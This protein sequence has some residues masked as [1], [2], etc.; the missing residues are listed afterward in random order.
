VVG[1]EVFGRKPNYDPRRDPVVRMEAAKLRARLAQYYAGEGATA[2]WVIELPKGGYAPVL[3]PAAQGRSPARVALSRGVILAAAL[4][5]LIAGGIWWHAWKREPFTIAVLPLESLSPDP[6]NEPFADG[7][8]GEIIRNLSLIEGISVRS[9]ASSFAFKGK[10]LKLR[11]AAGQLDV[12][13]VLDG[14][15]SRD[16]QNLRVNAELVRIRDNFLLWSGCFDRELT[17][18]FAIQDEISSG[19]VNGL[20]LKLGPG[21]AAVRNE[22]GG[23]R[24]LPASRRVKRLDRVWDSFAAGGGALRTS[25]AAGSHVCAGLRGPRR[26]LCTHVLRSLPEP[27][28]D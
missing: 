14:S 20:R 16:G 27:D 7:L 9:R 10:P 5:I 22:S 23:V 4:S 8:T 2:S 3:R 11:E 21:A 28:G 6:A 12:D 1:V 24:P 26:C 19:I 25:D 18:I 17:D 13:Y 15:V